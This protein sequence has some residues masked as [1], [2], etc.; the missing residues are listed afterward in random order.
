MDGA[1]RE[2]GQLGQRPRRSAGRGRRRAAVV[3]RRARQ[4]RAQRRCKRGGSRRVQS[5]VAMQ[6]RRLG[7][8]CAGA[9]KVSGRRARRPTCSTRVR[10]RREKQEKR[11]KQ[12]LAW[13]DRGKLKIFELNLKSFEYQSCSSCQNLQLWFQTFSHLRLGLKVKNSNSSSNE[14]PLNLLFFGVFSKFHVVT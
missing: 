11:S 7:L 4:S 5:V 2:A 10:E 3:T 1:G 13:F 8:E 12:C 9:A 6:A 14:N